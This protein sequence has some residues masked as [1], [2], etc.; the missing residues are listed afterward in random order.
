MHFEGICWLFVKLSAKNA[1]TGKGELTVVRLT[2]QLILVPGPHP[3]HY[4]LPGSWSILPDTTWKPC[5]V[6][7]KANHFRPCEEIKVL[8][9]DHKTWWRST[10]LVMSNYC[11]ISIVRTQLQLYLWTWFRRGCWWHFFFSFF[12]ST[13]YRGDTSWIQGWHVLLLKCSFC[14]LSWCV[15]KRNRNVTIMIEIYMKWCSQAVNIF[16]KEW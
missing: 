7:H 8:H 5:I 9:K 6:W 14:Y 4:R 3:E 13:F 12:P 10:F 15:I 1:H 11:R 16:L 2:T